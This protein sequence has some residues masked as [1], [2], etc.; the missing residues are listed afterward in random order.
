MNS[1]K[2]VRFCSSVD[3]GQAEPVGADSLTKELLD[4]N[5]CYLL[6]CG[7]EVFVW[8]GRSTSLDERKSASGAAEVIC[9]F[10]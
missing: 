6:D 7:L 2:K 4:T 9:S 1:D 8:M 10:F 5:R 3:K